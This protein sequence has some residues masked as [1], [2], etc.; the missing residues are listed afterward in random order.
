MPAEEAAGSATDWWTVVIAVA[1]VVAAVAAVIGVIAEGRRTRVQLGLANLWKLI[2]QWDHPEMRRRR[3]RV[4][5]RLLQ[6]PAAREEPSDEANDILNTFELLGYLV[7]SKTLKLEDAWINFPWALSWWYV[8]EVGIRRLREG[9]STVFE[10][11]A[12]LVREFVKYE[13]KT[14]DIAPNEVIPS[15]EARLAFLRSEVKLIRR[16]RVLEP[17]SLI[18]R[19]WGLL[20]RR[21]E[22]T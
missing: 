16:W 10:D 12:N 14:R 7:R 2:E 22:R 17:A 11:Y 19:V 4:A 18:S 21:P 1:A 13:A 3:A 5:R 6:E 8:Y 9:D 15:E 20:G